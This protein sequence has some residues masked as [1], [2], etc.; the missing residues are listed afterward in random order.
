MIR[1]A[2]RS[3]DARGEAA[4]N[5]LLYAAGALVMSA[6][7]LITTAPALFGVVLSVIPWLMLGAAAW[8]WLRPALLGEANARRRRRQYLDRAREAAVEM[9]L[10]DDTRPDD[11]R[12]A[13]AY[14]SGEVPEAERPQAARLLLGSTE[15]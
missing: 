12:L 10:D 13:A 15:P 14:L 7:L 11:R 9:L 2:F 4:L 3:A 6:V 5:G 8:W 1:R